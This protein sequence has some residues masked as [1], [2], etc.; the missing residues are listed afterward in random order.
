MRKGGVGTFQRSPGAESVRNGNGWDIAT[1][2][3]VTAGRGSDSA[4]ALLI[5]PGRCQPPPQRRS[6]GGA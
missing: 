5:G 4:G 2:T 3:R 1:A 6:L